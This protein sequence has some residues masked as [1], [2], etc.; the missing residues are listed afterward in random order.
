MLISYPFVL[1]IQHPKVNG[2]CLLF[3]TIDFEWIYITKL[4]S[5]FIKKIFFDI[6]IFWTFSKR[7]SKDKE[8]Y[9]LWYSC[10][11]ISGRRIVIYVHVNAYFLQEFAKKTSIWWLVRSSSLLVIQHTIKNLG[12][13][14][15]LNFFLINVQVI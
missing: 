13:R 11:L 12:D 8:S 15:I 10:C 5:F 2:P 9:S 7:T 6:S 4:F 3:S 1:K 14:H